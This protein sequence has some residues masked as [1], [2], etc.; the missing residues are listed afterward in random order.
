VE[1]W[2]DGEKMKS[3]EITKANLFTMDNTFTLAGAALKTG[4]HTVELRRL[5]AGPLYYNAYVSYFTL[6]DF[7][8]RAGLEIKVDRAYY[9]LVRVEGARAEENRAGTRGQVAR[10][11][12]IKYDR[13]PLTSG[14]TVTSGDLIEVEL[15]ITSKNDYTY[16]LFEDPKPSGFEPVDLRSG[17]NGNP[18]GAYVEFRDAHTT[19]F[20]QHLPQSTHSVSYRLRA[21][22]PGSVSALPTRA[23]AMYAPELRAN[24]DEMKIRTRDK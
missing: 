2:L 14:A 16:L 22:Q 13:L 4:T 7:I 10:A 1:V 3:V 12:I 8:T 6:E 19:F 11:S 5:G 15:T 20:V 24:S 23:E 9:K 18:L 21:E 17:Y